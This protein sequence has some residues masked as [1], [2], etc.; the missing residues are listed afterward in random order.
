[1]NL[2]AK[3]A[4][5]DVPIHALLE[6][7]WSPRSFN[8]NENVEMEVLHRIFEAARWAPSSSNE[9]PWR[10]VV[11]CKKETKETWQKI[12]DTLDKGNQRWCVNAPVLV[13]TFG[14]KHFSA[15]DKLNRHYAYDT[16][17]AVA[18]MTVEATHQ[19]LYVHQMAGFSQEKIIAAFNVPDEYEP[20][21]TIAIGI[22]DYP[23]KL[24]EDLRD[25]E[26]QERHRH[27]LAKLV[28]KE[29]WETPFGFEWDEKEEEE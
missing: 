13:A 4:K 27:T 10:F 3:K 26:E 20:L 2:D 7:R 23:E 9:Q 22:I 25:R 5:T 11:G 15:R 21:T 1:M 19:G 6:N 8:P 24:P 18:L 12:Y 29:N 14:K 28:F 16:G 17:Q